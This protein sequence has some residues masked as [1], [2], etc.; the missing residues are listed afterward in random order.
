MYVKMICITIE[1]DMFLR[2]VMVHIVQTIS[3]LGCYQHHERIPLDTS[4]IQPFIAKATVPFHRDRDFDHRYP[5]LAV[6]G[7]GS[8]GS[9]GV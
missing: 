6:G 1:W 2:L 7:I 3:S 5:Q 8:I 9:I 4:Y